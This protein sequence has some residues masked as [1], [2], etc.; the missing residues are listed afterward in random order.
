MPDIEAPDPDMP[1]EEK[2]KYYST[3][4]EKKINNMSLDERVH[5]FEQAYRSITG[6]G[7]TKN[8]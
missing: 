7:G 6:G 8:R 2:V 4:F 5:A 1:I 3:Q